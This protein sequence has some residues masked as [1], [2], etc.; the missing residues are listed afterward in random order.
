MLAYPVMAFSF[1]QWTLHDSWFA[2]LS[3]VLTLILWLAS[4]TPAAIITLV[5]ISQTD[6]A[7]SSMIWR[8]T[9]LS[10]FR[11]Y[12]ISRN[13]YTTVCILIILVT[14]ALV[15]FAQSNGEV[16]V[17]G[18]IVINLLSLA[19]FSVLK[20]Y[21]LR[22]LNFLA[23]SQAFMR[24]VAITL[25]VSFIPRVGVKPIPRV[26]IGIVLAVLLSVMI[27]VLLVALMVNT[28]VQ[29]R[30]KSLSRHH[31]GSHHEAT[32]VSSEKLQAS[33][34][35]RSVATSLE[36]A[37]TSRDPVASKDIFRTSDLH[38]IH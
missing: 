33:D 34:T 14:A 30:S 26:V 5:S 13:W 1:Y 24:L 11:P 15:G 21:G 29:L 36:E 6:V 7:R 16:Q 17:A 31:L 8:F 35:N 25:L 4:W 10:F 12:R 22:R 27:G 19:A 20:P 32:N 37:T 28:W 23:F 38:N 9:H 3:S 18:L 2:V